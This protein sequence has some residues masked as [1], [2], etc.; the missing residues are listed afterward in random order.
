[1][2]N[3]DRKLSFPEA[4][5]LFVLLELLMQWRK[6]RQSAVVRWLTGEWS[7]RAERWLWAFTLLVIFPLVLFSAYTLA[8][9]DCQIGGSC[10]FANADWANWLS[11]IFLSP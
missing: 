8:S 3:I 10:L 2:D 4:L 9:V 11:A 5:G 7:A 6:F 1:V